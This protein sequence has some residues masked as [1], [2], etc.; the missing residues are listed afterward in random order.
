MTTPCSCPLCGSDAVPVTRDTRDGTRYD[1]RCTGS[2]G[3]RGCMLRGGY[4]M[5]ADTEEAAVDAWNEMF[6]RVM[7]QTTEVR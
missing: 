5:F 1:V 2:S 3:R 7:R 6:E 4:G